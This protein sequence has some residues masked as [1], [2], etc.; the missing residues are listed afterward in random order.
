MCWISQLTKRPRVKSYQSL[1]PQLNL[2]PPLGHFTYP[3]LSFIGGRGWKCAKMYLMVNDSV[4]D[5]SISEVALPV[6]FGY[7]G[8]AGI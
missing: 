7:Q 6:F 4:A 8:T 2:E 5:C 3:P 1:G